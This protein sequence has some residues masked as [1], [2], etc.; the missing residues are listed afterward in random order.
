MSFAPIRELKCLFLHSIKVIIIM[1][2]T[3]I[4]KQL[5][6]F[7]QSHNVFESYGTKLVRVLTE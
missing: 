5:T 1:T 7:W 2:K 6:S 4:S 3:V